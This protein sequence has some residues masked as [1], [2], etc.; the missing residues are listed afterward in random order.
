[1]RSIRVPLG[2]RSYSIAVDRGVLLR[3]GAACARLKLGR[4]CVVITDSNVGPRYAGAVEQSL[5]DAGFEPR[6][7]TVP[8]GEPAKRLAMA[9]RCYD[10]CAAHRLERDSFIVALGGGV[11]GD[12]AGFVAATYLRRI[13]FIQLPTTLLAQV[14]SSVGG[15]T[16]VNLPAGKNLVGAFHQPRWVGCDIDALHTLPER[17]FRSGLAEVVK[18]GIISDTALFRRLERDL[19]RLLERQPAVLAPVIARCCAIKADVIA[20]DENESGPRAILNFG[21]TIGHGLE[22]ISRYGRYLHGEAVS[23]G[24]VAASA[25]SVPFAGL[26]ETEFERIRALLHRAGLPTDARLTPRQWERLVAAMRLDKKVRRGELQFVL[27]ERIGKA[28][29]G[30]QL[31]ARLIARVLDPAT[32]WRRSAPP[33]RNR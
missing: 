27:A 21:H 32:L 20:R 17:E 5:A 2:T 9:A 15:K 33:V 24:M 10:A 6:R 22:V 8:A 4:R 23:V 18:Y 25:L 11:V 29:W 19:A 16:A 28:I 30:R 7:V 13:A 26:E 12:L 31:P 3:V 1:M 14:D